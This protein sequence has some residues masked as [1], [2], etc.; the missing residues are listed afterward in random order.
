MLERWRLPIIP[1]ATTAERSDSTAASMAI[2]K[3]GPTSAV[4]V[5]NEM[6]GMTGCGIPALIDPKRLPIVSTGR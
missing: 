4:T 3:A 6:S 2:V 5:A 1:S